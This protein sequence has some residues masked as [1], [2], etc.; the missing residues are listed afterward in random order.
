MPNQAQ[1]FCTQELKVL[2]I[3]RYL[4]SIGIAEYQTFVGIRS[5]E[6]RRIAK[7]SLQEDKLMPLS[8]TNITESDV[9]E[10]WN[11][12]NFD[13]N[14]KKVSGASNC[15][16]CFLKGT[17]ILSSLIQEKPSRSIWWEKMEQKIGAR[18]SKDRPTYKQ[19]ADY[20]KSQIELFVDES[21]SCFCGD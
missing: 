16:L 15:D 6:P 17:K 1:R 7:I 21:I 14:L 9:F 3:H 4:K 13:L 19:M 5:D 8:K 10:F 20:Q 18:F 11:N 12:Q 2:T